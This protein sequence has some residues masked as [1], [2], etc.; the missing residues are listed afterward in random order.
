MDPKDWTR[1]CKAIDYDESV[2]AFPLVSVHTLQ[3]TGVHRHLMSWKERKR[4]QLDKADWS[5]LCW[6]FSSPPSPQ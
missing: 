1:F 6:M 4:G 5:C 2:L 3:D